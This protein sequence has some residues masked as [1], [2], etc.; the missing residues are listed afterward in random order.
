M[1]WLG[2][3]QRCPARADCLWGSTAASH[4]LP[5]TPTCAACRRAG[6]AAGVHH[7]PGRG[8]PEGDAEPHAEQDCG[9]RGRGGGGRGAAPRH[10]QPADGAQG[11]REWH[12]CVV[13]V[14]TVYG[15]CGGLPCG[16]RRGLWAWEGGGGGVQETCH[17]SAACLPI[18]PPS[19]CVPPPPPLPQIRVFCRI[20]P[21]PRSAVQCLPD[22]LTVRLQGG[23]DGKD[24]S[25][26]YDKVF[27]PE[28]SQVR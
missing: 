5:A 24:H 12:P 3:V 9:A 16:G 4:R 14:G 17:P 7:R 19:C 6:G 23:P 25:F 2:E 28:A 1:R 15:G 20:R 26:A 21:N 22:G 27:R 8:R 11:Q 13:L 10:P 18:A